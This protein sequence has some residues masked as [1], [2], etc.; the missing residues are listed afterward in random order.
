M[1]RALVDHSLVH[2]HAYHHTASVSEVADREPRLRL[3]E[4]VRQFGI[5]Q[6]RAHGEWPT[7]QERH[8]RFFLDLAEQAEPE[9]LGAQQTAW[10]DHLTVDHDNLRAAT[11]WAAEQSDAQAV[12]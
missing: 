9:L 5:E 7:M 12:L 11:T 10:L 4:T 3:L 8:A 2:Y 1:L 6:L